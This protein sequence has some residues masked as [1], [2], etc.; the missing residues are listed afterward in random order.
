[1]EAD[2]HPAQDDP[3]PDLRSAHRSTSAVSPDGT[4]KAE[5]EPLPSHGRGVR[6]PASPSP[7]RCTTQWALDAGYPVGERLPRRMTYHFDTSTRSDGIALTRVTYD[8]KQLGDMLTD[9]APV[10]DGYRLHDVF[11][12]AFATVLGWSPVTRAL[13]GRK[14]RS[15]ALVDENEDGGRAIVIEEGLAVI[16]FA[17]YQEYGPLYPGHPVLE[18]LLSVIAT[19]VKPF[20]VARRSRADWEAAIITAF[21]RWHDLAVHGGHGVIHADLTTR[22][23]RFRPDRAT[24]PPGIGHRAVPI[25]HRTAGAIRIAAA[26]TVRTGWEAAG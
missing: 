24:Q 3:R 22:T 20:E 6:L 17:H 25:S 18:M 5:R 2:H 4:M 12:L 16:V 14:R 23:L 11:H 10:V 1:M 9:A 15:D 7:G 26:H 21:A 13:L 19:T 8:G